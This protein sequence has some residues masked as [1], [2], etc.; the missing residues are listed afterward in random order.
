SSSISLA[1]GSVL[2]VPAGA[3]L[4]FDHDNGLNNSQGFFNAGGAASTIQNDG[5]IRKLAGNTGN[6][7]F[8]VPHNLSSSR[9]LEGLSGTIVIS[10]GGSSTGGSFLATAPGIFNFANTFTYDAATSMTGT[11]NYQF[12]GGTHTISG[13]YNVSGDTTINGGNVNF[14]SVPTI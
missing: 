1:S 10:T 3:T 9:H 11:G 12:T 13:I 7:F 14:N 8:R 6:T 5:I 4:A 2:H